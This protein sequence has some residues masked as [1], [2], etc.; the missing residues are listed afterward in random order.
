MTL[1]I[2]RQRS[3]DTVVLQLIGNL[4]V[5]HFD[6]VRAEIDAAGTG[7]VVALDVNGLTLVSVE[8]IR[9]LNA[10]QDEGIAICSASPYVSEWMA[11]ERKPGSKRT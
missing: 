7:G 10:C 5:E 1:R 6:E 9:F 11:L 3:T 2:D 4:R 8:G